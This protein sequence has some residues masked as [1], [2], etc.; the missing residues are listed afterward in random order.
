MS[1]VRRIVVEFK[2][3]PLNLVVMRNEETMWVEVIEASGVALQLG[4]RRGDVVTELNGRTLA[5]GTHHDRIGA[6]IAKAAFP[7]TFTLWRASA[8]PKYLD[9]VIQVVVVTFK[10]TLSQ[11]PL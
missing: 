9:T 2:A 1:A 3:L 5:V 10:K 8:G 11:R 6:L 4:V 7:L